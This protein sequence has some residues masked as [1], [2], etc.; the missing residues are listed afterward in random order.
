M[1][2]FLGAAEFFLAL[3]FLGTG[4]MTVLGKNF[5]EGLKV[6]LTTVRSS[7]GSDCL[8]AILLSSVRKSDRSRRTAACGAGEPDT[9]T[10][11]RDATCPNL[12]I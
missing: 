9:I 4:F 12:S 10:T 3:R 2:V 6:P 11:R 7:M 1:V 8:S 5:V